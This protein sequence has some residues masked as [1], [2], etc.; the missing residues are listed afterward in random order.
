MGGRPSLVGWRPSLFGWEAIAS[1]LEAIAV[2]LE[3]IA[4][5]SGLLKSPQKSIFS[6]FVPSSFL[7]LVVRPVS[8]REVASC[9]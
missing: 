2:R 9:S 6:F 3:A 1:R 4:G 5:Q 8:P 7:F